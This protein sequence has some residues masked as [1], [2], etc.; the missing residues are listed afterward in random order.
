MSSNRNWRCHLKKYAIFTLSF[1]FVFT[2]VLSG[3]DDLFASEEE[4]TQEETYQ[5]ETQ[6]TDEELREEAAEEEYEKPFDNY[7]A[8]DETNSLPDEYRV[9]EEIAEEDYERP[10]DGYEAYEENEPFIDP[11]D[12]KPL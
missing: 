3:I 11:N 5:E 10:S 9:D 8:Y 6:P 4:Y 7:E 2:I 12:E 1:L